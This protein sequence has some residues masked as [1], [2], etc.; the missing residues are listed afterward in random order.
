[1]CPQVKSLC[2][3]RR[4]WRRHG[5]PAHYP[6]TVT[7]TALGTPWLC[8]PDTA[9][10]PWLT[11]LW[12]WSLYPAQGLP[13]LVTLSAQWQLP[14]WLEP[15]PNGRPKEKIDV[16]RQW[17]GALLSPGMHANF[18][19]PRPFFFNGPS[20]SRSCCIWPRPQA[21]ARV[22]CKSALLILISVR[23]NN[24]ILKG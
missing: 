9:P 11:S 7:I 24:T 19:L 3:G 6:A 18:L 16:Q 13:G 8:N 22:F 14:E 4:S 21:W 2:L 23:V 20:V 15:L 12:G 17:I 1:M 10:G 5:A